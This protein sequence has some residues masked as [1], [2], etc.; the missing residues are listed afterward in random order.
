MRSKTPKQVGIA[1]VFVFFLA[2][3]SFSYFERGGAERETVFEIISLAWV[4][5]ISSLEGTGVRFPSL[6]PMNLFYIPI[7][8]G[9]T[10]VFIYQVNRYCDQRASRA[11]TLFWGFLGIAPELLLLSIPQFSWGI[12]RLPI[13]LVLIAGL[14][15][16]RVAGPQELTSPWDDPEAVPG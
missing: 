8:M 9:P 15:L 12:I 5:S 7:F 10:L 13:P 1:L 16:M 3:F 6:N 4:M 14:I 2:P 11:G